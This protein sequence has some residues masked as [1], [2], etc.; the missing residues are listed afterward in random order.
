MPTECAPDC[1]FKRFCLSVRRA[2]KTIASANTP[3]SAL[4]GLAA[5]VSSDQQ[6]VLV[7]I[8]ADNSHFGPHLARNGRYT[9][10]AKGAEVQY[11]DFDAALIALREMDKPR[12]RRPNDAGNWGIVSGRDWIRIEKK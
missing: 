9:V 10:G 6:L 1:T 4:S 3:P 11:D 7:P 5:K 8:A 2:E 12:W